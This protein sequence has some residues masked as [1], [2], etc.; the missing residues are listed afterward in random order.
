VVADDGI[1]LPADF[2][3]HRADSLGLQLVADLTQQLRGTL[4]VRRDGGT[5]FTITFDVDPRGGQP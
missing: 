2:D 3:V 5:T 4:A 1:G